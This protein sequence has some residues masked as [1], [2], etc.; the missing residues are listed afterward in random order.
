MILHLES[1]GCASRIDRRGV[2][3]LVLEHDKNHTITDPSRMITN[4][5]KETTYCATRAAWNGSKYEC[6]LCHTCYGSLASLNQHLAS[7]RHQDKIYL[8]PLNTCRVRFTTLSALCQHIESE[9]CGVVK[10]REVQSVLNG[11]VGGVARLT[12]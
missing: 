2:N 7:P 9:K 11:L 1:G 12:L 10:F 6:Y 8:C 5:G 3:R 4:G